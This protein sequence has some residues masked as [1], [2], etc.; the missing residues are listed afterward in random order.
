MYEILI[1]KIYVAIF[2]TLTSEIGLKHGLITLPA[3]IIRVRTT[4][5]FCWQ[6]LWKLAA[7]SGLFYYRYYRGSRS[8][9]WI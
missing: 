3:C 6:E 7:N 5:R 8:G 9:K 4:D 2:E 1:A